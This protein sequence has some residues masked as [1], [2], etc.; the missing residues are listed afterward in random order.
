M[1]HFGLVF[2][3][4]PPLLWLISIRLMFWRNLSTSWLWENG[5]DFIIH[6]IMHANLKLVSF[7]VH[8]CTDCLLTFYWGFCWLLTLPVQEIVTSYDDVPLMYVNNFFSLR[9][10]VSICTVQMEWWLGQPTQ[11]LKAPFVALTGSALL[12]NASQKRSSL[13]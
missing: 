2:F 11:P 8:Q 1:L 6:F 13:T 4:V 3:T 12:V 10:C 7:L 5:T 9:I